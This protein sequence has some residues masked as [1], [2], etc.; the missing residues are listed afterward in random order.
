MKRHSAPHRSQRVADQIQRDLAELIPREVRDP[1]AVLV[2][3]KSVEVTPDYAH[4][5]V[6]VSSLLEDGQG[7][8]DALNEASALLHAHLFK[9]LHIHTVPHLKFVLDQSGE[10]GLE[11]SQLIDQANAVRAKE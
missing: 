11:L 3:V 8:V 1:R 5:K 6:Y 7:A 10:R 9:R 2:T 4:A